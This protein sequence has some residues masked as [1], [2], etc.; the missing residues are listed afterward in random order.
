MLANS[1][2]DMGNLNLPALCSISHSS[3]EDE[4]SE[5]LDQSHTKNI[6]EKSFK[7]PNYKAEDIPD[8]LPQGVKPYH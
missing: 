6:K 2:E 5:E 1:L 4:D 3:S 7:L 8:I